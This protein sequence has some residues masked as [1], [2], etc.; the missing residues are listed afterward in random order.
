MD[1]AVARV[2]RGH[3][4]WT[5]LVVLHPDPARLWA[6]KVLAAWFMHLPDQGIGGV[7]EFVL[8]VR[9]LTP[10]DPRHLPEADAELVVVGLQPRP[11]P[12]LRRPDR[13]QA[14]EPVRVRQ[15]LRGFG[16]VVLAEVAAGLACACVRGEL[17]AE[18]HVLGGRP[19]DVYRPVQPVV[20]LLQVWTRAT[21]RLTQSC[22]ARV[23][24][25]RN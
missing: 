23:E 2:A 7:E 6:P 4:G 15:Q 14:V 19:D 20:H 1:P 8:A 16:D 18:T 12:T 21:A 17:M 9:R 24:V 5:Q 10:A 25:G 11:K 3:F 13:W 22:S